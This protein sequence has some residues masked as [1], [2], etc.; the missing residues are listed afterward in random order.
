MRK[1]LFTLHRLDTNGTDRPAE[2]KA[3][4]FQASVEIVCALRRSGALPDARTRELF[5]ALLDVPLFS[6][7]GLAPEAGVDEYHRWL[8]DGLLRS[9]REEEARYLAKRGVPLEPWEMDE[10]GPRPSKTP[11]DLLAAALEGFRAPEPVSYRGGAWQYDATAAGA[12][13]R[14]AFA[15]TQEH[16]PLAGLEEAVP[17]RE[18]ALALAR[19]GDV[20]ATRASV[21]A[22]LGDLGAVPVAREADE[23]VGAVAAGGRYV[24]GQLQAATKADLRSLLEAG[25]PRFDAL[26]VERTLEALA[27]H[28]YSS[29]V[30]DPED[31][32]FAD[33][34]LVKR[35][36]LAWVSRQALP[37]ASPFETARLEPKGETTVLHLAGAFAGLPEPLGLLHAEGLV[38]GKGSFISNDRVRGGLVSPVVLLASA[39][40]D[41]DLLRF[42]DLACRAAGQL[43]AALAGL[44]EAGRR[45]AWSA[46]ARGLVS[47]ARRNRLAEDG[48]VAAEWLSPSDL[49]RVGRRL[50]LEPPP[51]LPSVPAAAEARAAWERLVSQHG[52]AGARERLGELGP[53][54]AGW[55]GRFRLVDLDLPSWER[56]AEYR[57]PHLF[58]DRLYDLKVVVARDVVA[59]GDPAA[60][61]PL[62]LGEALD[63]LLMRARM[64]WAFDWRPLTGA[65]LPM[66]PEARERLLAAAV[67]KGLLTRAEK[68]KP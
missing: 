22:L 16:V 59:A 49:F 20:A 8:F 53:R 57:L 9:L 54:P 56:L 2:L 30:L 35:H 15:A 51:G 65:D 43:P 31:L 61:Y 63:A 50:A 24:L 55:A 4:L 38:Y 21:E 36:A 11:D 67:E 66:T 44:P 23:R 45:S 40:V 48:A 10:E 1:Y 6:R 34:L 17:E 58:A 39:R 12:A 7:A 52:E 62:Y 13:R 25:L 3:G 5:S 32:P 41:D 19:K 18:R 33:A 42:V 28:V 46:L 47:A 26:R 14:R 27:V 60:L 29:G 37:P 68:A 64:A